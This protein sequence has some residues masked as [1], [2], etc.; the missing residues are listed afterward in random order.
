MGLEKYKTL[1]LAVT[2]ITALILASPAL[3]QF[4]VEPQTDQLTEMWLLGPDHTA[5]YPS[6]VTSGENCRLYLDVSNHLGSCAYYVVEVKFRSE[7]QSGPNSFNHTNSDLPSIGSLTLFAAN[8]QT[9]E[10]PLDITFNYQ[11]NNGT[12]TRLDIQD[13]TINGVALHPDS[14]KITYDKDKG[15]F[16]GNLF[17]ELYLYNQTSNSFQYNERYNSL[18]LKMDTT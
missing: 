3:Q 1:L 6:N 10:L 16:Y 14:T 18:W 2:A 13:I 4:I 7:D 11:V 5:A 8:D 15:A 12:S 17:F 9:T